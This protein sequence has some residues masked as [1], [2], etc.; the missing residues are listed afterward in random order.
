MSCV[1]ASAVSLALRLLQSNGTTHRTS[2][3]HLAWHTARTRAKTA[4]HLSAQCVHTSAHSAVAAATRVPRS[5]APLQQSHTPSC[6]REYGIKEPSTGHRKKPCTEER[7]HAPVPEQVTRSRVTSANLS[8]A[9]VATHSA[10]P[11][12]PHSRSNRHL[13]TIQGAS[14]LRRHTGVV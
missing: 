6:K 8:I 9:S 13:P 1:L 4:P 3:S 14:R 2:V 11:C 10:R 5:S 7:E 12:H